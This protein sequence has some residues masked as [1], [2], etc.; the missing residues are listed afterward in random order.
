MP[1]VLILRLYIFALLETRKTEKETVP[2]RL[3]IIITL[4]HVSMINHRL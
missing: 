2:N 1:A 4:K 3:N